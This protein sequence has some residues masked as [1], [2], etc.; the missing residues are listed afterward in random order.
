MGQQESTCW[1]LVRGAAAGNLADRDE[2]ARRYAPVI[3]AYVAARWRLPVQDERVTEAVQE[4]FLQCFKEGGALEKVDDSRAGGFRAY[5]YGV[6]RNV[7]R[8]FENRR[9]R[10]RGRSPDGT[11]SPEELEAREATL[12]SVFDRAWA[13]MVTREARDLMLVWAGRDAN[14][15]RRLDILKARYEEDIP[16]RDIASR[17][18]LP[19]L[20]VYQVLTQARKEFRAALLQIM[21]DY[22]PSDTR[23]ELE[24]RCRDLLA[25][26]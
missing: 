5:L 2:F 20:K 15:R 16:P 21:S 14:A 3:Q 19:P 4:V 17:L 13:R 8:T 24:Q 23:E 9:A 18:E 26:L 25:S 12:S 1:T 6:T 10:R 11:P 7:T 22:H